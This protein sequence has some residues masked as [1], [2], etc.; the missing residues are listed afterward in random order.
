M[1]FEPCW[2]CHHH[3]RTLIRTNIDHPMFYTSICAK[4]FDLR[5]NQ[6]CCTS[7]EHYSVEPY[8]PLSVRVTEERGLCLSTALE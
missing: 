8:S 2:D 5:S 1:N 7:F 4:G 6:V 3:Q